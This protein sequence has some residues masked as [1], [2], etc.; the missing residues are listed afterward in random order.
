MIIG[1]SR[2]GKGSGSG[3]IRYLLGAR[4]SFGKL[5]HPLPEVVEGD[6]K[7]TRRLIDGLRFEWNYTSG[8]LSFSEC[9]SRE[10][11]RDVIKRFEGTAFAG[12]EP[13]QFNILWVRHT[14]TGRSELHFVIPRCELRSGKS[15]NI[16][17]PQR[18]SNSREPF[19][20]LRSVIN[21]TY[22]FSDPDDPDRRQE[23]SL[24]AYLKKLATLQPD[25]SS[26]QKDIREEITRYLL[27][28]HVGSRTEVI[29]KLRQVGFE[30]T[31]AGKT[32]LGVRHE[33]IG[34]VRLR[35]SMFQEDGWQPA[36]PERSSVRL[37]ALSRKLAMMTAQR[38]R[39]NRAYYK[40]E[41]TPPF[42]LEYR[43]HDYIGTTPPR[44]PSASQFGIRKARSR[45]GAVTRD[46]EAGVA[47]Y[48]EA[49]R[50]FVR[51]APL[52]CIRL[53]GLAKTQRLLDAYTIS[54]SRNALREEEPDRDREREQ[55]RK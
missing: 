37:E 30:I 47:G 16:A 40:T 44:C 53:Q 18:G 17:P 29:N 48:Q 3:P 15:L 4:D 39:Y 43:P 23:L 46:L 22:G 32:Y 8:V 54:P 52:A 7:E 42:S 36:K 33:N 20:T 24:P 28:S 51:L 50:Q 55:C 27:Q 35:G 2:Y 49:N 9:I 26:R 14:H 45:I 25:R 38:A 13:D 41:I 31:R 11:E 5:R 19:D 6:A 34:R 12:L 10:Q 1:F 21:L